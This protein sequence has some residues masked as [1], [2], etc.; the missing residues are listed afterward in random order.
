MENWEEL[1]DRSL[2]RRLAVG[3]WNRPSEPV[4]TSRIRV[5]A[6]PMTTYLRELRVAIDE[7]ITPTALFVRAL[8]VFFE[9]HPD[10]NVIL[11]GNRVKRRTSIDVFCQVSIPDEE[12]D[13]AD[14]S[15]MKVS[16]CDE[17]NIVEIARYID[18]K[19]R[20]VREDDASEIGSTRGPMSLVPDQLKPWIVRFV[21]W[22]VYDSPIDVE[23]FGLPADPFGS[24]M[25]SNVGSL[26]LE[27]AHAPLV[28]A[29]RVP[30]VVLPGE[31]HEEPVARD[32]EVEVREMLNLCC[33]GD[34]R[35]Y[36]G[37]QASLFADEMREMLEHPRDYFLAPEEVGEAG[38]V[39]EAEDVERLRA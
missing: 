29:S 23:R 25:L 6:E 38:E 18:R 28:P 36:D 12:G 31:I 7:R 19:A 24:V 34:H 20:E 5:E 16:D 21:E 30:L 8:G 32:G 22:L 13:G 33:T 10:L 35:C 3:M 2:W 37:Y 4:M 1:P 11:V 17:R 15:G 26:G 27:E 9:R 14:L 39:D